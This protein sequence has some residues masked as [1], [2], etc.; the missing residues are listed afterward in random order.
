MKKIHRYT[1]VELLVVVSIAA[2]ILGIATPAFS[3]MMK[4]G[5]MTSTT[6][7]LAA[8]I[9]AA[10]SYAATN[11]TYVAVLFP[12]GKDWNGIRSTMNSNVYRPCVVYKDAKG[13]WYFD[14]WIDGEQWSVLNKGITMIPCPSTGSDPE[15]VR[16]ENPWNGG[17]T[18]EVTSIKDVPLGPLKDISKTDTDDPQDVCRAL[19]FKPNGQ[20]AEVNINEQLCFRLIEGTVI[21][22]SDN[23]VVAT[24]VFTEGTN[25]YL[26]AKTFSI[27]PLTSKITIEDLKFEWSPGS[28]SLKE[29]KTD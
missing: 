6:R 27:H 22:G 28:S 29:K 14:T 4:G 23:R 19:I 15:F 25:T 24:N 18:H 10:R 3:V 26:I 13:D 16:S 2:V 17:T 12:T 8:K 9:K 11:N 5:A 20:L 1:L 7:E 21:S